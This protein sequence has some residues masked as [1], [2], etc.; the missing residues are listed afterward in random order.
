MELDREYTTFRAKLPELLEKDAGRYV[1]IHGDEVIGT[2]ETKDQALEAGYEHWL[3]EAF[4]V[5]QI[6][7]EKKPIRLNWR[8]IPVET[9]DKC[10]SLLDQEMTTYRAKLP[11][12]LEKDA[13]RYVL[14]HGDDVIG[15]YENLNQAMEEGYERWLFEPFLVKKIVA[16]EQPIRLD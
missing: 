14:I 2:F 4:L 13:G 12:L 3:F 7:A 5:E 9:N 8:G 10:G 11:E 1:L 16:N 6:V 15:T